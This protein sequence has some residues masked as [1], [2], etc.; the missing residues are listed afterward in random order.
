MPDIELLEALEAKPLP[1]IAGQRVAAEVASHLSDISLPDKE[2][3]SRFKSGEI[4]QSELIE[5]R[6]RI[7][8][9]IDSLANDPVYNAR[10]RLLVCI[11]SDIDILDDQLADMIYYWASISGI[12]E[13]FVTDAIRLEINR[14]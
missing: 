10:N 4:S 11:T 9:V 1:P 7:W 14:W 6:S 5:A 12:D 2:L 13:N 3:I 8:S